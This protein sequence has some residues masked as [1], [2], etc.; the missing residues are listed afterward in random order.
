MMLVDGGEYV[1]TCTYLHVYVRVSTIIVRD[2][3]FDGVKEGRSVGTVP[4]NK[5]KVGFWYII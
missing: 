3:V 1:C 5:D 2:V 4:Q